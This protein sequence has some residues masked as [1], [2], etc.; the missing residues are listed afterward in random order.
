VTA[1]PSP[2]PNP[3]AQ[4]GQKQQPFAPA[5][6]VLAQRAKLVVATKAIR[7][8]LENGSLP[9]LR[10]SGTP[11]RTGNFTV[12]SPRVKSRESEEPQANCARE[13]QRRSFLLPLAIV[14]P[15]RWVDPVRLPVYNA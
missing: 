7:F 9:R 15:L 14:Q 10:P 8:I 2:I 11:D 13:Q 1:A 6:I 4:N 12:F 5:V 3:K